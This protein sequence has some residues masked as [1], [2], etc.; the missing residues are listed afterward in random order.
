MEGFTIE[1]IE[2]MLQESSNIHGNT[3]KNI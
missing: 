2:V 1:N 3:C